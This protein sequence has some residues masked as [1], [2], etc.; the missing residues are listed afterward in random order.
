MS[1]TTR[2]PSTALNFDLPPERVAGEP[3]EHRGLSRDGVRL[4]VATRH[5][6]T[7]TRFA[8]L[9]EHLRAGDLLVINTS[10][11]LP[12]ALDARRA[13]GRSAVVHVAGPHPRHEG[14]WLVE[15]RRP[16]GQGPARDAAAG[17]RVTL[18]GGAELRLLAGEPDARITVGSRL[19]HARPHGTCDLEDHLARHGRPITYGYVRGSWPLTAYQPVYARTPG[20]AE[21]ASAGRPFTAELITDLVARGVVIAPVELHTGVSSLEADEPLPQERYRVP[22]DTARLV[23]HTRSAGRR[24]IAVGTTVTRALESSITEDG[25]VRASAGW[26]SLVLGPARPALVVDG[27]VTGWHPPGASHLALL[28]AVAGRRL[29][30]RAYAE[31][32]EGAYLWHEFG[33]SCLLLP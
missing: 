21:M 14:S 9:G 3:P 30:A 6:V 23:E 27:L 29:V 12:S 16:D 22:A 18:P 28:E 33:D 7:H 25:R 20:S 13:N 26:T 2:E 1:T 5:G 17:E 8:A 15:L 19:W 11:T 31:A 32:L 4:L 24:V 10:A